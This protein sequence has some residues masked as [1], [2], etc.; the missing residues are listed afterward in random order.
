MAEFE[1]CLSDLKHEAQ[2][3]AM[4][5]LGIKEAFDVNLDVFPIFTI[6]S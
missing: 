1:I 5:F 2:Q 4:K 6:V 3:R